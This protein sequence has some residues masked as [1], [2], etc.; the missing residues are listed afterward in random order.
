MTSQG[1]IKGVPLDITEQEL[2]DNLEILGFHDDKTA[3]IELCR[4]SRKTIDV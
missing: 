3:A 2:K 1:V 4:L